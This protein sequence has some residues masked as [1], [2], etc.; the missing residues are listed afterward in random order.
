MLGIMGWCVAMVVVWVLIILAVSAFGQT[1]NPEPDVVFVR[2]TVWD[3]VQ[4]RV[5]YACVAREGLR[6][7][8]ETTGLTI[9]TA[10]W[11]DADKIFT[12]SFDS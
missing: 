5:D 1:V 12:G 7:T 8:Y 3:Y 11:P 9:I 6:Y 2:F 10:C 4:G